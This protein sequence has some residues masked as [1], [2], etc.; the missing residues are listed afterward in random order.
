MTPQCPVCLAC[1][2]GSD[3]SLRGLVR[4]Q[5]VMLDRARSA[6]LPT[7][8]EVGRLKDENRHLREVIARQNKALMRRGRKSA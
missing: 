7:Q 6:L 2:N 1:E 8:V 5:A 3:E 4:Y